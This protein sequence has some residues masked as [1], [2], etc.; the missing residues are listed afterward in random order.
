MGQSVHLRRQRLRSLV[1]TCRFLERRLQN[2]KSKS[3]EEAAR[4]V[5]K[6][7]KFLIDQARSGKLGDSPQAAD[8]EVEMVWAMHTLFTTDYRDFSEKAA[9]RYI[10]FMPKF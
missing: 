6:Y 7:R 8:E 2:K 10:H 4:L 9:G 1:K 5:E 3:P